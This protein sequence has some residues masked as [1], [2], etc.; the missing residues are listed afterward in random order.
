MKAT[1]KQI[2]DLNQSIRER[3]EGARNIRHY[4]GADRNETHATVDRLPNTSRPGNVFAGY[5]DEL[6]AEI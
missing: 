5:T 4:C 6:I 3:Y 1:R 2:I